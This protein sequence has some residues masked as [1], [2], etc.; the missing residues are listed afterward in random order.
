MNLW[1]LEVDIIFTSCLVFGI[2]AKTLIT[3]FGV[4][5]VTTT[6]SPI[7]FTIGIIVRIVTVSIT[8]VLQAKRFKSVGVNAKAKLY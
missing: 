5:L 2:N 7:I 8:F 3:P 6:I 4:D 1:G